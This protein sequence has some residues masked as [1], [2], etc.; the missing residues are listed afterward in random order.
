MTTYRPKIVSDYPVPETINTAVHEVTTSIKPPAPMQNLHDKLTRAAN[1]F[2]DGIRYI[3]SE[4]VTEQY[5]KNTRSLANLDGGRFV[6]AK[7]WLSC[8]SA[9]K[10]MRFLS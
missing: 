2:K 8:G 9:C 10:R 6:N 5:T 1:A 4:H 7:A 3:V